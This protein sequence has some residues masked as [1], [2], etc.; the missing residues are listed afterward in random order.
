MTQS[1]T[2]RAIF[3]VMIAIVLS[4]WLGYSIITDQVLTIV[5]VGAVGVLLVGALLGHRIWLLMIFMSALNVTLVKGFGT[6][7]IAKM[8][9]IGFTLAMFLMRR[10][11]FQVRIGELEVWTILIIA[12]IV[13]VY[14]RNPVGLNLLGGGSV[15]GK[16]YIF[17]AIN[18]GAAVLLSTLILPAKELKWA[19]ALSIFGRFVGEPLNLV[20]GGDA[21]VDAE[22]GQVKSRVGTFRDIGH[23]I[24]SWLVAFKSPLKACFH[25]GWALVILLSLALA[26]ASGYR[27][28]I[29][30]VGL[31]YAVAI[32]YHSGFRGLVLSV[33]VGAFA[34]TALA[35][36]NINFPLPKNIQRALSPLPGAWSEEV[37]R[38]GDQSTEWRWEMWKAALT[39]DE[40]IENK[41]LG[42]GL[43]MTA[44]TL[45]RNN[46]AEAARSAAYGAAGGLTQ[47]QVNM[48]IGGAY[49]SGPVH[50]I[51]TVGYVGLAILLLALIRLAVHAHRQ[52]RRCWGTEWAP[53]AIYFG[54]YQITHP[55]FF[56]FVFGEYHTAVASFVGGAA[57]IRLM[58][59]NIPLPAYVPAK[60][61]EHIPLAVRRAQQPQRA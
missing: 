37:L 53:V 36:Y 41:T 17:M 49:H 43:G 51:R 19:M 29:A 39:T 34:L 46:Q 33:L 10:L 15:G 21:V 54:I 56:V 58:E 52:I 60:R 25:P 42:D 1:S 20:R 6:G 59:R 9:F 28:S 27:N 30:N 50:T 11:R 48:M 13:Q 7:E 38:A 8:M 31:L 32:C 47:M 16:P 35:F 45:Q 5:K 26:A 14:M 18:V 44:E 40:W 55:I 61:R 3:V 24:A 12:C 22:T 2:I 57:M 4:I 23:T